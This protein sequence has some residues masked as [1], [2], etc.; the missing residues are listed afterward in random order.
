MKYLNEIILIVILGLLIAW[1]SYCDAQTIKVMVI[2]SGVDLSNK[3]IKSHVTEP[4]NL[5]HLDEHGHGTAVAGLILKDT[6]S[7]VELISCKYWAPG[8][9][10]DEIVKDEMK[11]WKEALRLKVDFVNYSSNGEERIEE[12]YQ[13]MRKLAEAG[14]VIVVATGNEGLLLTKTGKCK[15]SFPACYDIP[16]MYTVGS[17]Q[18]NG[19]LR[20]DSNYTNKAN[21]R[22]ELGE[23]VPVLQP[24]GFPKREM[25]GTSMAAAI[26]TNKLVK[27]KCWELR[28]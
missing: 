25:S 12:E 9:P 22:Y 16:N 28:K 13:S 17:L 19:H 1:T 23:K 27:R 3:E 18:Q 8:K 6:C 7:M 2:D 20:R 11:C 15:G 26:Y 24:I 4:W 14:T 10:A 5:N 21:M